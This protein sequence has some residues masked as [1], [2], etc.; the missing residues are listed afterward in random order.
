MGTQR[1]PFADFVVVRGAQGRDS[2]PEAGL[3][4][5]VLAYNEKLCVVEH[6]MQKGWQ[7][8]MH[9]HPHEQAVYVVS[10]CLRVSCEGKTT[11][12]R[13]GDSFVVRGGVE[14][15]AAALEDCVVVDVFTPLREDYVG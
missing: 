15:G 7:G 9:S 5:K 11:D 10:G 12:I 1:E 6:R 14:H 4:R 13:S 2:A 8:T 3:T